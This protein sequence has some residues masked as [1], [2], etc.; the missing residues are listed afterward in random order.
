LFL[1]E[2]LPGF[3]AKTAEEIAAHLINLEE[4]RELLTDMGARSRAYAEK[5]LSPEKMAEQMLV[6]CGLALPNSQ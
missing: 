5:Y 1:P 2:P 4:N 3:D 6:R